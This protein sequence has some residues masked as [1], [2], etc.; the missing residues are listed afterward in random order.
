[1]CT[2][3]S[4]VF[5]LLMLCTYNGGVSKDVHHDQRRSNDVLH[6]SSLRSGRARAPV[7]LHDDEALRGGQRAGLLALQAVGLRAALKNPGGGP[8]AAR[9]LPSA[10][11]TP[12]YGHFF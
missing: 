11:G 6:F 5:Q 1:M 3:I 9:G 10:F 12:F 4:G 7:D 2:S 8:P